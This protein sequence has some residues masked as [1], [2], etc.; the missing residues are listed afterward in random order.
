M[1]TDDP[2]ALQPVFSCW[3][4]LGDAS[5]VFEGVVEPN[6]A[7]LNDI[8]KFLN[9]EGL[10]QLSMTYRLTPAKRNRFNLSGQISASLTQLCGVTLDPISERIDEELALEC[11]PEKQIEQASPD[12]V[13]ENAA[14]VI[15]GM[16]DDPPVPIVDGRVDLGALAV[17][18]VASAMNPYPRKDDVE[19][20]WRDPKT[21]GEV[22]PL[23]P[24]AELAKLKSK[25]E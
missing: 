6:E 22:N 4:S 16:P 7:E 25:G 9:V 23:G 17:E 13:S 2:D 20:D 10:E 11:V 12:L 1:P 3:I 24:F 14:P 21:E 18:I 19:F 15:E 8:A 5:E